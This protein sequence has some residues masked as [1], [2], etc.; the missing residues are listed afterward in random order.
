MTTTFNVYCDESCHLEND[1]QP[2]MVLGAIWC[3]LE[4]VREISINIREIKKEYNIKTEFEIKWIKVSPAKTTF[5]LDLMDYF[6]N[7]DDLHFRGVI[8]PDKSRL[9]HKIYNQTHDDW[10]YKMYFTLLKAILNPQAR[11]QIY[12]DIKDTRGSKKVAKLHD[13]L[14]NN[15]LDF[16]RQIIEK[17]Q[18]VRSHE[19]EILQLTDLLIGTI[20]YANRGL[21]NNTA[22]VALVERMRERSGYHLTQTTLSLESKVNLLRWEASEVVA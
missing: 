11:Y 14:S 10:Y 17:L 8:I 2:I 19:V 12:L 4:K 21:T 9:Q 20:S 1:H 7:N 16:S 13:V 5:Y 15:L 18:T 6:F 22:K 3:P